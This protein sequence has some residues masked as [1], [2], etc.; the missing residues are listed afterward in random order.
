MDRVLSTLT[1]GDTRGFFEHH[2]Y[3]PAAMRRML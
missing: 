1:A 2:G 3:S